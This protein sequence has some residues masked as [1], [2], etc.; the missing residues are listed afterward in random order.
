MNGNGKEYAI[1]MFAI[2]LEDENPERIYNDIIEIGAVKIR[3]NEVIDSF[4]EFIN[5]KK[6]IPYRI[7]KLTSINDAMVMDAPTIDVILPRFLEFIGDS[8]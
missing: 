4:S 5:P 8:V 7:E 1:A 6:P 2:M 3:N